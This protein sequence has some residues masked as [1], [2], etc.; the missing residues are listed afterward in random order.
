MNT[1]TSLNAERQAARILEDLLEK[2]PRLEVGRLERDAPL[3]SD[4]R[5]DLT[6][7]I[8]YA[9]QTI[10]LVVEVKANGQPR[11]VREAAAQ[12]KR[13]LRDKNADAVPLVMAPY[14]SE[15][16]R[17]ACLKEGVG[18]ADFIGNIHIAFETIFIDRQV[19]G[20][21]EPE[22]RGL[23]SL[24]K[25]KSA[26]ILRA[27]LRDPDRAWR[28]TELAQVAQVSAGLVS[29]VGSAL[30]ERGWAEQSPDG[31][32]LTD[33][34]DLLDNWAEEYTPPKTEDVR[35]YTHLHGDKLTDSLRSLAHAQGRAV[36]SSFSAADWLAPY[37]RQPTTYFYADEDGLAALEKALDL[38][39]VTKGANIIVR[40]PD[41]DGVLDDRLELVEGILVT[42]PVQTYLDLLHA[43]ERGREGADHL[44]NTLL[45]WPR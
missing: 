6:V 10:R 12:L 17:E 15:Q 24:F 9:G 2:I 36:L 14:L 38:K 29:T 4:A 45:K 27:L 32:V 7:D 21:P 1:V 26:R 37:V 19:A 41:E 5:F 11:I 35:R 39:P 16:A 23:R 3:D 33:P 42:S 20:R 31:L 25:P 22:R 30:R 28:I 13:Q 40:M 43:G 34:N 44:R 18:Y 8:I